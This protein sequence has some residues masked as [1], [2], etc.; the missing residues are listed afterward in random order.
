MV[1]ASGLFFIP[2][3]ILFAADFKA[4][5]V[6]APKMHIPFYFS[7]QTFLSQTTDVAV[8]RHP[9]DNPAEILQKFCCERNLFFKT[10][11]LSIWSQSIIIISPLRYSG[12]HRYGGNR[13][14]R[15]QEGTSRKQIAKREKHLHLFNKCHQIYQCQEYTAGLHILEIGCK[16]SSRP[17]VHAS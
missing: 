12:C 8:R 9:P 14:P 6:Q 7:L 17:A 2:S 15:Q 5:R 13:R 11:Y 4:F 3:D 10:L 16:N 1:F